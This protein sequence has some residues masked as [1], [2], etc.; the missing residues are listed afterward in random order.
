M[1]I[2]DGGVQPSTRLTV[3]IGTFS[4]AMIGAPS[5]RRFGPSCAPRRFLGALGANQRTMD[6]EGAAWRR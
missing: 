2:S 4:L 1:S 5:T 6:Q 3:A